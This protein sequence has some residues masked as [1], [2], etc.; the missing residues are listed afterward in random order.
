MRKEFECVVLMSVNYRRCRLFLRG[1]FGRDLYPHPP[2]AKTIQPRITPPLPPL[3]TSTSLIEPLHPRL[4]RHRHRLIT[5]I[6]WSLSRHIHERDHRHLHQNSNP[7]NNIYINH[8][9]QNRRC[10]PLPRHRPRQL[11]QPLRLLN[12]HLLRI[13]SPVSYYPHNNPQ[14]HFRIHRHLLVW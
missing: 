8:R 5:Q 11:H 4:L 13:T 14:H 6:I 2:S 7:F 10:P 9:F 1:L 3:L 12:N